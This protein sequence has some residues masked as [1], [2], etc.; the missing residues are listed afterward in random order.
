[1]KH[2]PQRA[3]SLLQFNAILF[4]HHFP[5]LWKHTRVMR[6]HHLDTIGKLFEQILL[7]RMLHEVNERGLIRDEEFGFRPR[8]KRSLHL[9]RLV[10]RITTNSG[11][12][13]LMSAVF[14][15]RLLCELTLLKFPFY[16]VRTILYLRDR[17]F[18]TS[19]QAA[20]SSR[21]MQAGL[22]QSE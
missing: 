14:L 13:W 21:A 4:I 2:F 8:H 22:A 10:E 17:T 11:E 7:A 5:S 12:N 16:I 20:T 19:F 6:Y 3:V 18:E 9:A 1:V 15:D